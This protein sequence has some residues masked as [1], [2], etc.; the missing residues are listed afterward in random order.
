MT[1][2]VVLSDTHG[3]REWLNRIYERHATEADGWFHCGDSELNGNDPLVQP[4]RIVNGNTDI[5]MPFQDVLETTVQGVKI[6][7]TH[8]HLLRVTRGNHEALHSIAKEKGAHVVLYGH[9]HVAEAHEHE[10][11]LFLNPG[12]LVQPRTDRPPTYSIVTIAEGQVT[13]IR[14]LER[15][16]GKEIEDLTWQAK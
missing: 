4:F 12:S 9:T 5:D 7:Q 14:F 16:S 3:D 6:W 15:D 13:S 10:G 11:A 8:G 2:L 1:K